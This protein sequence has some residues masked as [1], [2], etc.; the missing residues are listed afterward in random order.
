MTVASAGVSEILGRQGTR[1]G[2][3][4]GIRED[5]GDVVLNGADRPGRDDG[6]EHPQ[7]FEGVA[8]R[9]FGALMG[10]GRLAPTDG[11][12]CD[13]GEHA[14]LQDHRGHRSLSGPDDGDAASKTD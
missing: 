13:A 5:A 3:L 9:K 2:H 12:E 7:G 6:A 14:V 8:Y 1:L 11:L 10:I 4:C